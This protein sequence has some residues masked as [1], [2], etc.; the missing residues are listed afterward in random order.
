MCEEHF[1]AECVKIGKSGKKKLR[2]D[3]VPTIFIT[4]DGGKVMVRALVD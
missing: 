1:S 3:S 4:K 2:K